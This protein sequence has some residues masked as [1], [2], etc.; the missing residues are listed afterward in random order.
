LLRDARDI[1][2]IR[3]RVVNIDASVYTPSSVPSLLEESLQAIVD[4]VRHIRNPVEAAFFLWI[5]LAYL[6]PFADGNKRTSRLSAN[7]PL[8]VCT[9]PDQDQISADLERI[10]AVCRISRSNAGFRICGG[11]SRC[12]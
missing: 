12:G 3:R 2:S 11:A 5:H 9:R 10:D 8:M 6:Q 7:M 1:G 4:K